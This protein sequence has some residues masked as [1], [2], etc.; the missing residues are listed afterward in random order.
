MEKRGLCVLILDEGRGW[1]LGLVREG[2]V[3]SGSGRRWSWE[4]VYELRE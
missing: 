1:G 4:M 2:G 3:A